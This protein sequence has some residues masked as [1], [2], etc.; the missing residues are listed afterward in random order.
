MNC[1]FIA[2][3]GTRDI[4]I[5]EDNISNELKKEL[6]EAC[7]P[8]QQSNKPPNK[9]NL[10][11][12]G[13][14]LSKYFKKDPSLLDSISLPI[15]EPC[16][17]EIIESP[18]KSNICL[19]YLLAT[20]QTSQ[21]GTEH[22]KQDTKTISEF[23][24]EHYLPS[25]F[26]KIY[27]NH[28][29]PIIKT[30]ELRDKPNDYDKMLKEVEE[31]FNEVKNDVDNMKI[32]KIFGEVTGG[33]PQISLA[34]IINSAKIFGEKVIMIYKSESSEKAKK[35]DIV[36][37]I[38]KDYE[39]RALRRLAERYDFD[40]IARNEI[41]NPEIREI[42]KCVSYRLNF[43]FDNY[44]KLLESSKNNPLFKNSKLSYEEIL[45]EANEL[46]SKNPESIFSE[47]Y[48]N[49]QVKLIRDECAD[50]IGRVWRLFEGILHHETCKII[51]CSWKEI[52]KIKEKFSNW[53]Q[54]DDE[55]RKFLNH[56]KN[57]E[58][59]RSKHELRG[60]IESNLPCSV[61]SM[62]ALI[63][64]L[65]SNENTQPR[66]AEDK[67]KYEEIIAIGSHL[68]KFTDLRNKS[69]IAHGFEPISKEKLEHLE[70]ETDINIVEKMKKLIEVIGF[71]LKP[72]FYDV[73]K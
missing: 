72:N 40:A 34:V 21:E 56:I 9:P 5:E 41:Y 61:P 11:E 24:R 18:E 52:E 31:R 39:N 57:N 66:P 36:S 30:I 44:K 17:K 51:K 32:E 28:Q 25:Y 71:N 7:Y 23:L 16:I 26:K 37:K 73:F 63:D 29:P 59:F 38:L 2:T 14:I 54:C 67:R 70:I 50:F 12:I 65:S 45:E 43:D 13:D 8:F 49:A 58:E 47:L 55:G 64:Y 27:P 6:L 62:L 4:K 60:K 20:N 35:I 15:I 3:L 33:T 48:W 69:I 68:R 1:A 22:F 42:A 10:R 19:I 46:T 53:V